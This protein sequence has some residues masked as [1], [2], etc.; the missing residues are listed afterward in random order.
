MDEAKIKKHRQA[1]NEALSELEALVAKRKKIDAEIAKVTDLMRA[2]VNML[3]DDH[4]RVFATMYS[5]LKMP[6]GLSETIFQLLTYSEV[7]AAEMRDAL[8]ANG[9]DLS[10]HVNAL[11]SVLTTLKRLADD[12]KIMSREV[13]GSTVYRKRK[14]IG[15]E[16]LGLTKRNQNK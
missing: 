3:P 6:S 9:Y 4:Q 10:G 15:H 12:G 8:I 5:S 14:S 11:A 16:I 13:G 1:A 2:N 7:S